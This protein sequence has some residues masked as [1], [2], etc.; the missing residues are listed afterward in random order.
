[1]NN[2]KKILIISLSGQN[3]VMDNNKVKDLI[4]IK[5]GELEVMKR[6]WFEQGAKQEI[7]NLLKKVKDN[8]GFPVGG[9]WL[10]RR[11]RELE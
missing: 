1:M 8:Q 10:K 3:K 9:A 2:K 6:Q 7:E 4:R 11:L 5:Q